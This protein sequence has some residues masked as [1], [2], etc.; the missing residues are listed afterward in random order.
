MV[1][2]RCPHSSG[3]LPLQAKFGILLSSLQFAMVPARYCRW[4]L[5]LNC[6]IFKATRIGCLLIRVDSVKMLTETKSMTALQHQVEEL[7][8]K[9]HWE[10]VPNLRILAALLRTKQAA[11][12]EAH[13]EICAKLSLDDLA[14]LSQKLNDGS[15]QLEESD[16]R[17][18]LSPACLNAIN[19]FA[20]RASP[21]GFAYFHSNPMDDPKFKPSAWKP[22]VMHQ[23]F[24]DFHGSQRSDCDWN[25]WCSDPIIGKAYFSKS[26][27]NDPFE[28]WKILNFLCVRN[29]RE[30][31]RHSLA[32]LEQIDEIFAEVPSDT[33]T[34]RH[35]LMRAITILALYQE[36][37]DSRFQTMLPQYLA[38]HLEALSCGEKESTTH[39]LS[40]KIAPCF[41]LL[42]TNVNSISE[43]SLD[44][45]L[46]KE[47][48]S[49]LRYCDS[50]NPSWLLNLF[51]ICS[52]LHWSTDL[53]ERLIEWFF[54]LAPSAEET[55]NLL[56]LF[57]SWSKDSK[58]AARIGVAM[59]LSK[60]YALALKVLETCPID[61]FPS[62]VPLSLRWKSI[63]AP[64]YVIPSFDTGIYVDKSHWRSF[65]YLVKTAL[66]NSLL[67]INS[68]NTHFLCHQTGHICADKREFLRHFF[69]LF[70]KESHLYRTLQEE[71]SEG[72]HRP[73]IIPDLRM[74]GPLISLLISLI[75][76]AAVSCV[77]VPFV[78]SY[79]FFEFVEKAGQSDNGAIQFY[80]K[81]YAQ[82]EGAY[83]QCLHQ[84]ASTPPTSPVSV[85]KY[86][87]NLSKGASSKETFR[88]LSE[89]YEEKLIALAA[90]MAT[91]T[92]NG[93]QDCR[94]ALTY[95]SHREL[96]YA[97]FSA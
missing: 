45:E 93:L 85:H 38:K 17:T 47:V 91:A 13:T 10:T 5:V 42:L 29:V 67:L 63:L 54:S 2:I 8:L 88:V 81:H 41:K 46:L 9:G 87:I 78:I 59:N 50:V 11:F 72:D 69:S 71:A 61:G 24:R 39:R 82:A 14:Q 44:P 94:I 22:F 77:R 66:D 16:K 40:A 51:Y 34:P 64:L 7:M 48:Y 12:L 36:T 73:V 33:K 49:E 58:R 20:I 75:V 96:H 18:I 79:D 43:Q 53:L 62:I 19:G 55:C 90:A 74:P 80:H 26:T 89:G 35:V 52:W 86:L 37:K 4:L 70:L 76:Q 28:R 92:W 30:N 21:E 25:R 56:Q 15:A 32:V 97:L 1:R 65:P 3:L 27:W 57:G 83:N 6:L 95:L 23:M 68:M 60:H 31:S 84:L